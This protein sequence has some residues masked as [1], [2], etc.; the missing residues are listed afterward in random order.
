MKATTSH[1]TAIRSAFTLEIRSEHK[2]ERT[3]SKAC[4]KLT[5]KGEPAAVYSRL[6]VEEVMAEFSAER[7]ALDAIR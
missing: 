4:A 5:A 6:E 1:V 3:A 2:S 7:K